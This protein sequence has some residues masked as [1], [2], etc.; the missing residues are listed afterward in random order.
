MSNEQEQRNVDPNN[1]MDALRILDGLLQPGVVLNR[2]VFALAD[3]CLAT[4]LRAIQPVAEVAP[5]SK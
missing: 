5:E 1:P 3:M 2:P 4:L